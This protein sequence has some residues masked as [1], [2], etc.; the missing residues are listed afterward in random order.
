MA[1][2]ASFQLVCADGKRRLM[3]SSEPSAT[4]PEASATAAL[5][6]MWFKAELPFCTRVTL[7][8]RTSRAPL[9]GGLRDDARATRLGIEVI[10]P[11]RTSEPVDVLVPETRLYVDAVSLISPDS[12]DS[13]NMPSI[14]LQHDRTRS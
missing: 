11:R 10:D 14:L 4:P 9:G 5:R 13:P 8:C 3:D 7:F 12:S 2:S 6:I 1:S